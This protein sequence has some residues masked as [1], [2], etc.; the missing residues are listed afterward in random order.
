MAHTAANSYGNPII[1][2]V[3]N[4][5]LDISNLAFGRS[6]APLHIKLITFYSAAAGDVFALQTEL[7]DTAKVEVCVS[8][9]I[10]GGTVYVDF[11]CDGH[12]F[13]QG[14]VFDADIVNSGLSAND[15]VCIY[16]M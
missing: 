9:N 13:Q 7:G 15:R 6:G 2:E 4:A 5:D 14:L 1:L 12:I 8:Q 10:N 11:G 3:F 16:L